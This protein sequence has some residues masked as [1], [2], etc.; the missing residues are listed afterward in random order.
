MAD[1]ERGRIDLFDQGGRPG[2][3]FDNH[4]A[5]VSACARKQ[6]TGSGALDLYIPPGLWYAKG[7]GVTSV[8]LKSQL[9]IRGAGIRRTIIVA[10]ADSSFD[11]FFYGQ[12]SLQAVEIADLSL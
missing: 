3:V 11:R 6:K 12:G 1:L 2:G 10:G 7:D 4:G 5:L 9:R 8:P